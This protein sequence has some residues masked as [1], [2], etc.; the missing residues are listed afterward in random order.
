MKFT[1]L[2]MT[3]AVDAVAHCLFTA[4]GAPWRRGGVEAAWERLAPIERY[5]RRSAAGEMVLPA[6]RALPERPTAGAQPVFND[7]E[8]AE[9]AE[10]ASRALLENRSPGAWDRMPARRRRRLVRT[11]VALTRIA[12]KAMPLRQDPDDLIVP[13]HL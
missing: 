13:D 8:Y 3:A 9:A 5:N 2:E 7:A 12:V 4:T 6:L 1:E 10:D 11:T